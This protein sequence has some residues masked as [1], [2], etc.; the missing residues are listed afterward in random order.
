MSDRELPIAGRA[1]AIDALV[2]WLKRAAPAPLL[3]AIQ[4]IL[5]P[6]PDLSWLDRVSCLQIELEHAESERA[7]FRAL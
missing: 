1:R 6:A 4:A 5:R 7:F 3:G 2:R